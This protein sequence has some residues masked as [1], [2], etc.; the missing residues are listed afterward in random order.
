MDRVDY[1]SLIIQDLINDYA[2]GKLDLNPWYQRRSVWTRAQNAYLINTL[3]E[4]KPIPALYVRHKIDL[5][6]GKSLKE[7]VDGQQRSRAIISYCKNEYSAKLADGKT[8]RT[9]SQLTAAERERF[10]ITP[11]PAGYLL[12]A[13]DQDVIDIFGRINSVSKS[14]NPQERRNAAYSGEFKQ[15]ALR[16]AISYLEFWRATGIFTPNDIARMN[17]VQ[18][19]ADLIQNLM[20]GITDFS[21]PKLDKFYAQYEDE[22]PEAEEIE[23]KIDSIF[24]AF[25]NFNQNALKNTIFR[26]PP[27]FWSLGL[28]LNEIGPTKV[29]KLDEKLFY[30][31]AEVTDESIKSDEV[32][33]FRTAIAST[34]Q[35]TPSRKIRRKFLLNR[36]K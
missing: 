12:G 22:F 1:Q 27:I 25:L 36:L 28:V 13:T 4:R 32:I 20:I 11:L 24:G 8:R 16:K 2:D 23:A 33:E 34:T 3:M 18:F 26:R 30:I 19:V 35:R 9:F 5:E 10:L 17:E 6:A 29:K 14:L 15:F 7:I 31:D 21:Q